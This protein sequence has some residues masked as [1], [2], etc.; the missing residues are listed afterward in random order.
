MRG[1]GRQ[2]PTATSKLHAEVTLSTYDA[3]TT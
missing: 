1:E 2:A 3:I